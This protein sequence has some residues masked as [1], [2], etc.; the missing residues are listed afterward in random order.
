MGQLGIHEPQKQ[1]QIQQHNRQ[2][3]NFFINII[4]IIINYQYI[5]KSYATKRKNSAKNSKI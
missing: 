4:D 5:F 2:N 1:K 3:K